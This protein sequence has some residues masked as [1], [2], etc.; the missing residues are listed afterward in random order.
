MVRYHLIRRRV[1][2]RE[3]WGLPIAPT[4][5]AF[6]IAANIFSGEKTQWEKG[7]TRGVS[8]K[9][10]NSICLLDRLRTTKR[11]LKPAFDQLFRH[12]STTLTFFA[13]GM[14]QREADWSATKRIPV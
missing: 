8:L 13:L 10:K 9:G 5:E 14:S 12:F 2:C 3:I 6:R 11:A 7:S 4:S 1:N